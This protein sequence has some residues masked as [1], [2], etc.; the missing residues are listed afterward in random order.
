VAP[1]DGRL[2]CAFD[3]KFDHAVPYAQRMQMQASQMQH[4]SQLLWGRWVCGGTDGGGGMGGG[5]KWQQHVTCEK[6]HQ[7]P[8]ASSCNPTP[9]YAVK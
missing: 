9:C 4:T 1:R 2:E 3:L 6:R 7:A 8:Q 5:C